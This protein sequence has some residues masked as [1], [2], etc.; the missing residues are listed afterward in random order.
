LAG[1]TADPAPVIRRT[2]FDYT[3]D[4]SFRGRVVFVEGYD[5][6]IG[7]MLVS[8]ADVWL[9]TPRR[10]YDASGTSG[11]KIAMH[12]ALNLSIL[13]GWW[14]EGYDGRNGW[15]IGPDASAE[16]KDPEVQDPED[17]GYLYD[18]LE[19]SVVPSFYERNDDGIPVAWIDR[20]RA[21]MSALPY[22]FSAH[23]MV[24]EYARRFYYV[25]EEIAVE[26]V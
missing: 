6:E 21:A 20:M 18:L 26:A 15:A 4:P 22:A 19:T 11:Q 2:I 7:R 8:G 10:P 16:Y 17:A 25:G 14:P 5:M 12:G 24:S 1:I 23:R 9:N 3:R 13:D